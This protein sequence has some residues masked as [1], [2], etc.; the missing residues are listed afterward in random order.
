M[1][2][3]RKR[4]RR[5]T[6][7]LVAQ[8]AEPSAP[9]GDFWRSEIQRLGR[10]ALFVDTGAIIAC[11]EPHDTRFR[12]FFEEEVIGDRLVTSTYV[13][14]ETIRRIVKAK[15]TDKLAG[16]A[17]QRG[18]ELALHVLKGWLVDN[19]VVVLHVPR[20]VFETATTSLETH[21]HAQCDLMDILSFEIVRGLEQSRIVSPDSH[22]RT[23]GL[24]L[25]PAV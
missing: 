15:V 6:R 8:P 19:E 9:S 11:L 1:A 13:V 18:M 14:A 10:R 2:K 20:E 22:F 24:D 16:P 25:L 23:L 21:R 3:Q 5:R 12:A 4:I 17:G 7:V